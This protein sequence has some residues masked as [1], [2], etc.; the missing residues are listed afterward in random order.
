MC[1]VLS[2]PFPMSSS[3]FLLP[4]ILVLVW[5]LSTMFT[6]VL[7]A[8]AIGGLIYFLLQRSRSQVLK[9][10]DGWWG[11]GTPPDGEEDITIRPFTVTTSDEELEVS[12]PSEFVSQN[13]PSMA[14]SPEVINQES[15]KDCQSLHTSSPFFCQDL[16]KRI[17]Q[18]RPVASLEDSQFHYGFNSQYLEKVVSYWRNDFDWRR[19]VDKLNQYPHFKTRID[20]EAAL[21]TRSGRR[22]CPILILFSLIHSTHSIQ[23]LMSITCT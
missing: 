18:T 7:V 14:C 2:H 12:F 3:V 8:L 23:A 4:P 15:I 21:L 16:Y 13:S 5:T 9:A 10:E 22:C 20:G 17:D 19:Q 6:E 1:L 11:T